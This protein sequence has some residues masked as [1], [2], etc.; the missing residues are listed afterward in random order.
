M[1]GKKTVV[2]SITSGTASACQDYLKRVIDGAPKP[3]NLEDRMLYLANA[4][5]QVRGME[6]VV[7]FQ[8]RAIGDNTMQ[9]PVSG[10]LGEIEKM[11]KF[12]LQK[13]DSDSESK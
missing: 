3:D 2:E 12:N 7:S 9:I 5:Q 6:H 11:L 4:L 10:L 13:L 8:A 1:F